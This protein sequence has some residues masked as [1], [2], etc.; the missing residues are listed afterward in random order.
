M[1]Q[2]ACIA[3][4]RS[5]YIGTDGGLVLPS[6]FPF[7]FVMGADLAAISKARSFGEGLRMELFIIAVVQ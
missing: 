1:L 4:L 3:C 7:P 5:W 2:H 6:S